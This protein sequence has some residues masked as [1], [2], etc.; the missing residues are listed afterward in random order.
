MINVVAALIR[1]DNKILLAKRAT[2]DVD[3]LGKWEFPGG[4]IND[5]ETE[6]DA[7]EREIKEELGIK[8]KAKKYI[9]KE[10]YE[11]SLKTV[12]LILYDCEYTEGEIKL[13]DHF[14]YK[15]I[16]KDELLEYDLAPADIALAK[17]VKEME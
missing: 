14:D 2:G 7:I 13:H 9:T 15:W 8:I 6:K 17:Y 10:T 11:Y 1:K 4:K 12:N 5:K 3:V 16:D